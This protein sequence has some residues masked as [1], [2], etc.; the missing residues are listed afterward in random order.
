[1]NIFV[2]GTLKKGKRLHGLVEDQKFIKKDIIKGELYDTNMA[3]P[4][5]YKGNDDIQGEIYDVDT[6][7]LKYLIGMEKNAGY[8]FHN[9]RTKTGV[10][11]MVFIQPDN[12]Y[13][14]QENRITNY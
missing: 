11:V 1:M 7:T 5:L 10:D 6:K 3:Y 12:H 2:Y 13:K 8:N 14:K 4:I 9:T